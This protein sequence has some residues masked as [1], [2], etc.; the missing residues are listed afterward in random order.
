MKKTLIVFLVFVWS[1]A[2]ESEM[3]LLYKNSAFELYSDKVVEGKYSATAYS[4][5]HIISDY[6]SPE[7]LSTTM[8][9]KFG[10]NNADNEL[11]VGANHILIINQNLKTITADTLVFGKRYLQKEGAGAGEFFKENS[12][13]TFFLDMRHVLDSLNRK[14]YFIYHSG[15]TLYKEEFKSVN[16]CGNTAPLSW[17][18]SRKELQ[19]SDANSDGIYEIQLIFNAIKNK[20]DNRKTWKLTKDISHFP[21][22]TSEQP[23]LNAL[24]NLSLEELVMNTT[25]DTLFDT[26]KE[27]PGVWTRDVSY[28]TLLSL[29][30]IA[31]KAA[32]KSLKK[33]VKNDFII[34]DT[35]TGGSWPVSSD[36]TTWA[37][38]AWEVYKVTGDL[39]WL[40][41]AYPV[42]ENTVKTDLKT[43]LNPNTGLYYGEQSFLDW[44]EQ[45]YPLWVEPIDIYKSQS[46]GTNAVHFRTYEILGEMAYELGREESEKYFA[47]AKDIKEAM[48]TYLWMNKKGYYAEYLYGRTFQVRSPR[49]ETLGEALSVLFGIA[50]AKQQKAILEN[51]EVLEYGTPCFYPQIPNIP[52]YHNNAIWPFVNA[53]Y[54]WAGAKAQNSKAVSYGLATTWRQAALFLTNKENMVAQSGSYKGTQINSD[55]QL[56]SVAG[57]L[58]MYYRVLFGMKYN[59]NNIEFHPFVPAEYSG[60]RSITNFKYR[61]ATLDIT[62]DGYGNG[63]K[64]MY[65]DDVELDDFKISSS[66]KG[67]HNVVIVMNKELNEEDKI[68]L[69]DNKFSL[70]T[71]KIERYGSDIAWQKIKKAQRYAIFRNGKFL[72]TTTDT[73]YSIRN[74]DVYR[75]YQVS[76][77]SEEQESFLSEPFIFA[78]SFSYSIYEAE[79]FAQAEIDA[80]TKEEKN[81]IEITKS[82]NKNI[83]FKMVSDEN[84]N[85][86]LNFRYANGSSTITS[87]NKCA[88][89]SLYVNQKYIGAIVMPQRGKDQWDNWGFTNSLEIYLKE[90][91]NIIE[92]KYNDFNENMNGKINTA[93]IDQMIIIRN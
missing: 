11:A 48:N 55:R 41:F 27:W 93:L 51:L 50:A 13:V 49:P 45:S 12:K 83:Q 36:R 8:E 29:A 63:I 90:G 79:E 75:E 7:A 20:D 24:Y 52:P 31:P 92:L 69:V 86:L 60:K 37:L 18:F 40:Y 78:S 87:D 84:R 23:L 42:I 91:V 3:G 44:R 71:P 56:W 77:I 5:T 34:Q 62:V 19:M 26:G 89:R 25:N 1:C 81:Y 88:I 28:S 38:A 43:L 73:V 59:V 17:N 53:F 46:L 35:G 2:A 67:K 6:T 22:F 64:T 72:E 54:T 4:P 47:I 9:V 21:Q 58:A 32:M 16:I 61:N 82:K 39:D 76:A 74:S 10:I 80:Q 57:N 30:M 65:L 15:D 70:E 33:K 66:I 85:C 68:N 14:G